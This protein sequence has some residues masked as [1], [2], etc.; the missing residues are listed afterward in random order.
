MASK[1]ARVGGEFQ[2]NLLTANNQNRHEIT[3]LT[4][5]RFVVVYN[6]FFN[7]GGTDI[8]VIG[9]FVNPDGTLSGLAIDVA[10]ANGIQDMP[11]VA[12]RFGGGF[13]TVWEDF[14]MTTGS[15]SASADIYYAV[16]SSADL[17]GLLHRGASFRS[18]LRRLGAG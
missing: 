5:G 15:P 17:A 2:V 9:Q 18:D 4:D 16:T 8:D 12:P 14:G 3:P 10:A 11:T 1:L 13:T 6:S 7:P